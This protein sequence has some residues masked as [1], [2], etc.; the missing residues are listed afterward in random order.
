[1]VQA[2]YASTVDGRAKWAW[3]AANERERRAAK[4]EGR[5]PALLKL[6]DLHLCRHTFASLMIDSGA[7]P[8]A[9]QEFMGTR[10]SRRPSI[11]T[12]TYCRVA[13]TRCGSGWMPTCLRREAL[14]CD[15][16]RRRS[17]ALK[18]RDA[19]A[20]LGKELGWRVVLC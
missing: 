11:P 20:S 14:M 4:D 5:A 19:S 12:G 8:K 6:I 9:I 2:P 3:T 17:P 16:Q 1:M 18:K 10:K 13:T 15:S 7:N